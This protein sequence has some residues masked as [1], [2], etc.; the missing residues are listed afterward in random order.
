[1]VKIDHLGIGFGNT[2]PI[3]DLSFQVKEGEKV[4]LSGKSGSGKSSV[5]HA[6]LGF[7]P[8]FEGRI[9]VGG[10]EVNS[11][12][13]QKI[14]SITA[15]VPQEAGFGL[16]TVNE[17]L[18]LPFTFKHNKKNIPSEEQI[19]KMTIDFGLSPEILRMPLLKISGGEKQRIVIMSA[20]LQQKK[21]LLLDEPTS[22]LD[23]LTRDLIIKQVLHNPAL[24]VLAASHDNE[25]IKSSH[26]NI[27]L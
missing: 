12:N 22:A 9:I 23:A 7:I 25:W 24:T 2:M 27:Q 1:M 26:K 5:I 19:N 15:W 3:K 11:D 21:V 20:L 16:N 18:R 14:R 17:L 8:K 6:I 10:H 4:V 13:I